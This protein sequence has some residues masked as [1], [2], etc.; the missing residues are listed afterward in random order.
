VVMDAGRILQR[1]APRDVLDHPESVEVARLA[2]ISNLLQGTIAALDPGRNTSRIDFERFSLNAPYIPGHF[3][4][5][6]IWVAIDPHDVRVHSGDVVP[7]P[8]AAPAQLV[9]VSQRAH[10]VRLEFQGPLFAEIS[11][12]EYAGQRDNKS[13]QVEFPPEALKIL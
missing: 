11:R 5:D 8:N 6:Q 9:R 13:W 1:G 12:E 3:R 7:P 4:G 2:G 10:S